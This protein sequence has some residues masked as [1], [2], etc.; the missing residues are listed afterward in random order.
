[1]KILPSTV[2]REVQGSY[3]ILIVTVVYPLYHEHPVYLKVACVTICLLSVVL[4]E[5]H[6]HNRTGAVKERAKTAGL[7]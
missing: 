6:V 1:M 7:E 2:V 4:R 5:I 3:S